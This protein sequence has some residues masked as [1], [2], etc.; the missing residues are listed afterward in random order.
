MNIRKF[1][2]GA[3]AVSTA[4]SLSAIGLTTAYAAQLTN[5]SATLTEVRADQS[6]TYTLTFKAGSADASL[7]NLKFVFANTASSGNT[8]PTGLVT[9]TAVLT[10]LTFAGGAD[11]TADWTLNKVTNGTIFLDHTTGTKSVSAGD[12][13]V[14][15]FTTI[16]NPDVPTTGTS[17]QCDALNDSESCFLRITTSD[18]AGGAGA[19]VDSTTITWT[20]INAV[21]VTATVD[22]IL[23]FTVTGVTNTD[24]TTNDTNAGS[25]TTT[26][27]TATALTFGNIT[28]GT[29]KL[30]QQK[31]QVQTNALLGYNVYNRW[32]G[33]GASTTEFM[34]GNASNTNNIDPFIGAAGTATWSAPA[35]W[36]T[37]T[38]TSPNVNSGWIG[39]RTTDTDV[40]N[41]NAANKY[42]PPTVSGTGNVVMSSTGPDNGSSGNAMYVTYKIE[43][44]AY[45]PADSYSG[46]TVYNVVSTY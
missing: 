44:N 40:A 34:A 16:T 31:L 10:S 3:L 30:S 18:T 23:T 6:S 7:K 17:G 19:V 21:S 43:V 39:V 20:V 1:L 36:A 4:L 9:T 41:F 46:T 26:T 5:A 8:A 38:G 29:P 12:T 33:T 32:I 42:G 27:S 24:I 28:V 11:E 37:P 15:V 14:A 2:S 25:G 35:T 22:P 13:I 45:Q